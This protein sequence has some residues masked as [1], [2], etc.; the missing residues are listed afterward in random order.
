MKRQQLLTMLALAAALVIHQPASSAV[1][2]SNLGNTASG[3]SDGDKPIVPV[4]GAIQAGQPA[5]FDT[6]YGTDGL[7]GG[8][9]MQ[10]WT[11]NYA[12][13]VDSVLSATITI[14]IADHDS[15]A[16][17]SQVDMFTLDGN[18]LTAALDALFEAGGGDDLEYNVYS[19]ALPG[20]FFAALEDGTVAVQLNLGGPGLVQTLF[21]LPGPNPPTETSTNGA[22]LI[23]SSLEIET[24]VLPVPEPGTFLLLAT[25]GALLGAVSLRR[26][27]G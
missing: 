18:P 4:L 5:P 25:V 2:V 13:I 16:S 12:P 17:G 6:G 14:G 15:A 24:G 8:N 26:R 3:L 11:H 20:S 9:F 23:F 27:K 1:I 7:F 19:L 21:P 22:F 10:G